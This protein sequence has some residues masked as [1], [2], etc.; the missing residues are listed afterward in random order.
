MNKLFYILTI[1]VLG[2]CVACTNAADSANTKTHLYSDTNSKPITQH[3]VGRVV[4][5]NLEG[6]FYGF[7]ADNGEKFLPLNLE[8]EHRVDG[9]RLKLAVIPQKETMTFMQFGQ[10]VKVVKTIKIENKNTDNKQEN[11]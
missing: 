1:S 6:G 7:I 10:A 3:I 9:K 11:Q 2:L 5:L 8:E 4:Y